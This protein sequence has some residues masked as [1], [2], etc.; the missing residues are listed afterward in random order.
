MARRDVRLAPPLVGPLHQAWA[1]LR[2]WDRWEDFSYKQAALEIL[3]D[4]ARFDVVEV[5]GEPVGSTCFRNRF[6]PP[7]CRT[8]R[9]TTRTNSAI[10][11]MANAIPK[12]TSKTG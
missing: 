12:T 11:T 1:L 7:K 4:L 2:A 10:T 9:T 8:M 5:A 3:V 6:D